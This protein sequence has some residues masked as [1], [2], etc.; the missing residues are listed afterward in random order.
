MSEDH[1]DYTD[2]TIAEL[3]DFMLTQIRAGPA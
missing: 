1:R 2:K 3:H